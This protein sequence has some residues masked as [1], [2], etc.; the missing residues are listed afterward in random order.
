MYF[1]LLFALLT[2]A[3]VVERTYSL[4]FK[5]KDVPKDFRKKVLA[6]VSHGDFK[7]AIDYINLEQE[8]G[9][10]PAMSVVKKGVT[11]REKA[12]SDEVLQARMD[13]DLTKEIGKIDN[14]TGF[15]S[16]FGNVSTLFGLLGTV[17]GL[18][19]SFAG[20]AAASPVERANLLSQGISEALNST[21]F[22]LIAAI[23]A[24]VFFA[25]FT[26]KTDRII[27]R[28]TE[29]TSEIY[30][31]LLFYG[32]NDSKKDESFDVSLAEVNATDESKSITN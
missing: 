14:R 30:H 4:Y 12:A 6:F 28:I 3:L 27:A 22:G 18:I 26:N 29:T 20:V 13:E 17:T 15:L 10:S 9:S 2:I 21:A 32:V 24:L 1:I 5:Y 11:L 25:I 31:D 16:M 23:P 7:G 8:K 19:S